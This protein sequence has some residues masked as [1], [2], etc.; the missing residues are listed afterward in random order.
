M[1]WLERHNLNIIFYINLF[2][3]N[4]DQLSISQEENRVD[5]HCIKTKFEGSISFKYLWKIDLKLKYLYKRN[6][7]PPPAQSNKVNFKTLGAITECL[8]TD[9]WVQK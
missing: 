8:T 5:Y 6:N 3:D 2:R 4:L 7:P 1:E 9:Y